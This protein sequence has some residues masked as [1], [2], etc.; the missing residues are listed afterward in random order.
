MILLHFKSTNGIVLV[1]NQNKEI[2]NNQLINIAVK[3]LT[4]RIKKY[5]NI[6]FVTFVF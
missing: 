6:L 3:T 4:D 2:F 5:L 1:R